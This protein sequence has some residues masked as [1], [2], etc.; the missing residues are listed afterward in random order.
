[1]STWN[2]KRETTWG[3]RNAE[4]MF[5]IATKLA[6]FDPIEL[7]KEIVRRTKGRKTFRVNEPTVLNAMDTIYW[8]HQE[9]PPPTREQALLFLHGGRSESAVGPYL[10]E[11]AREEQDNGAG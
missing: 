6:G 10:A 11:K 7:M 9:H 3:S 8:R 1:M 5:Q 4:D 2:P